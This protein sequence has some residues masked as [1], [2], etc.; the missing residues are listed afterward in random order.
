M[1][2]P[3]YDRRVRPELV[4]AL[5]PSG[6]LGELGEL[7]R[8]DFGRAHDLDL[9]LRTIPGDSDS[10]AT[11]YVGLTQVLHVHC[12]PKGFRLSGQTGKGFAG[13]L[14]PS[15]FQKAWARQQSLEQLA[16][17]WPEVLTCVS[18]AIN[19]TPSR[20]RQREGKLQAQLARGGDGFLALDREVV[21]SF[22]WGEKRQIL[23]QASAPLEAARQQLAVT[24]PWARRERGFGDEL[25]LLAVDGEGRVLVVEVKHGGDTAGIGWTP[26]QVALYLL[27]LGLWADACPDRAEVLNGMLDQRRRLALVPESTYR[28]AEP[29]QL[30]P[31]IGVGPTHELKNP[32]VANERMTAVRNELARQGVELPG[33]QIWRVDDTGAVEQRELGRL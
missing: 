5:A 25:D 3:R 19:A 8:G 4:D 2:V 31:V 32:K 24:H 12:D 11:L 33:L 22:P 16:A 28:V 30:V 26:A 27:I 29:V 17:S 9:Q 20:Y 1:S 6:E 18:A 13:R 10:R 15:F 21:V 7:V 23:E 14:D